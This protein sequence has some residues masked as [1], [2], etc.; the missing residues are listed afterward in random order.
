M[1]EAKDILEAAMKLD[2]RQR[3]DLA[4]ALWDSLERGDEEV[5][6]QQAWEEEIA[7]RCKEIDEGKAEF[8]EWSA[9]KAEIA[10]RLGVK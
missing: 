5:A 1:R 10:R 6:V 3:E 2:A 7:R 8:V 9:V 4:D